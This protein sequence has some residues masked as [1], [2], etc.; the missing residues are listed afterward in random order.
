MWLHSQ[1]CATCT[2]ID[3]VSIP[4]CFFR[5]QEQNV[6]IMFTCAVLLQVVLDTVYLLCVFCWFCFPYTGGYNAA[7]Q[8]P[9]KIGKIHDYNIEDESHGFSQQQSPPPQQGGYRVS[10]S[11]SFRVLKMFYETLKVCS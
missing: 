3:Q 11:I 4:D 2:L 9:R 8:A 1:T 5:N 6:A 10:Y 7:G